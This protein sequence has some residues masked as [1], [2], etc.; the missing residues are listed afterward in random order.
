MNGGSYEYAAGT[1]NDMTNWGDSGCPFI[2]TYHD[3]DRDRLVGLLHGT[4]LDYSSWVM[5]P[6]TPN[7]G[8]DRWF[9]EMNIALW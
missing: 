5:V 6:S 3:D 1:E 4:D 2:T 7:Y 8:D 9:D